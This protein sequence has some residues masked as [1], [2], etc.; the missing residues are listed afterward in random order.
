MEIHLRSAGLCSIVTAP[1]PLGPLTDE[2]N[3][4]NLATLQDI[5]T[6]FDADQQ[7]LT[8]DLTT[9][10]ECSDF[11]QARYENKSATN[12]NRL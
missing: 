1:A 3:Q 9:T 2:Y 10:K 12:S 5:Y 8:L 11:L 6:T 7:D 4:P